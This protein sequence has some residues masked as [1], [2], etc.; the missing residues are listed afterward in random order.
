VTVPS[1]TFLNEIREQLNARGERMT[2]PRRAILSVL[3]EDRRHLS[4]DEIATV[5]AQRDSSVHRASVYRTL[6]TLTHLGVVQHVHLG[7]GAT[8]YHLVTGDHEHVHLQCAT[9]G[10]VTDAP[11]S[12]LLDTA[13]ELQGRYAF[14]LDMGHV[15]LSGQCSRC[16][17][18]SS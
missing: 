13:T 8:V 12:L 3:A 10:E 14:T 11:S 7:H 9:C 2:R 6:E 15:A 16:S 1:A 17:S 18:G 5:V 4:A